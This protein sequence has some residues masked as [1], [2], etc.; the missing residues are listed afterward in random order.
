MKDAAVIKV[1]ETFMR[2]NAPYSGFDGK[3]CSRDVSARL[4]DLLARI[5]AEQAH[6]LSGI[7]AKA[8]VALTAEN[9]DVAMSLARDILAYASIADLLGVG[10]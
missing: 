7:Q 9:S 3:R 1:C 4:R 10:A 2:E 5:A 8:G 6:T